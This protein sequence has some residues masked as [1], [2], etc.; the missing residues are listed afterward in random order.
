MQRGK[1]VSMMTAYTTLSKHHVVKI[2]N[3]E[4][5]LP[6]YAFELREVRLPF[7]RH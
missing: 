5:I 3:E 7:H 6:C 4:N 2:N 1:N